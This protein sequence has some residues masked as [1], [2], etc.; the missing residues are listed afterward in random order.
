[1]HR[2]PAKRAT[3]LARPG[4][5]RGMS[6][7]IFTMS[8]L[9]GPRLRT[10]PSSSASPS[11]SAPR[12]ASRRQPI[13]I[14]IGPSKPTRVLTAHTS[15]ICARAIFVPSNDLKHVYVTVPAGAAELAAAELEACGA[16]ELK[17]T[18][19]GVACEAT[20][21]QAY[22]AC[23][24]SRVA[25]RVLL[26]IANF[27]PPTPEALYDGARGVDW[28]AHLRVDGT[29]AVD[30]TSTRSAITHTQFAALKVKDAM[31]DQFREATGARPSVDVD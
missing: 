17:V 3:R 1:M 22:R 29:L 28:S 12:S 10:E 18:R 16:T 8:G 20:L 15:S 2:S 24:W 11:A 31:V 27:D 25:S 5:A 26:Q 9:T 4:R 14:S 13:R 7:A 19:G 30:C 21:E 23:L 6:F